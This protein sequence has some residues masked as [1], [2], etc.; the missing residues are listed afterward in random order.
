MALLYNLFLTKYINRLQMLIDA[1]RCPCIQAE[2]DNALEFLQQLPLGIIAQPYMSL[3]FISSRETKTC[4]SDKSA[5]VDPLIFLCLRICHVK[6]FACSAL[7]S[8][9]CT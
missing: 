7:S 2:H 5:E 4:N 9:A 1:Y 3:A 8:S 6:S